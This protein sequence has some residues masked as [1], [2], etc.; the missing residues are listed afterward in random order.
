[1]PN[2][3]RAEYHWPLSR[4]GRDDLPGRRQADQQA[5]SACEQFFRH[6]NRKGGSHRPADDTDRL[7]TCLEAVQL[8]VV[9][10]PAGKTRDFSAGAQGSDEVAIRVQ[11][12]DARYADCCEILL[13][14][15]LAP[16]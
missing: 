5:A 4:P 13:P 3:R 12:A 1:M 10:G 7:A 16:L 11:D 8:G 15:R 2:S 9:A 6:Q 14:A